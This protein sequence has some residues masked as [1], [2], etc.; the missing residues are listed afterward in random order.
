MSHPSSNRRS[1]VHRGKSVD[2]S[3]NGAKKD[4]DEIVLTVRYARAEV[5]KL[6]EARACTVRVEERYYFTGDLMLEL[7]KLCDYNAKR[8]EWVSKEGHG[9]AVKKV[10]ELMAAN[11]Y[12]LCS[13]ADAE[14][15]KGV[16]EWHFQRSMDD[17]KLHVYRKNSKILEERVY[18]KRNKF[19]DF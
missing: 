18:C 14:K 13:T 2:H 7:R 10:L 17:L 6:G 5:D 11:G 9:D 16:Y 8:N 4:V 1:P 19:A 12:T 15:N 3:M